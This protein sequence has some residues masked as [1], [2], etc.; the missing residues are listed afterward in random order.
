MRLLEL[1]SRDELSLI[2]DLVEDIPPYA[3]LSHTWGADDDEVTFNDLQSGSGKSKA[4]YTK[5]QFCGEQARKDGLQYFWVDTCCIDKSSSAELQEAINSMFSWYRDAAK[6]YVYLSDVSACECDNH[7]QTRQTWESAFRNSKWFTRGWTLQELIAPKSVE[8]FS[9]ERVCLGNK[10]GLKQQIHEITGIPVKALRGAPLPDFSVDERMRWAEKRKTKKKEDKA[11][12]L[13]GIF[14]IFMPLIYGE[15]ENAFIRL[16]EEI[17][18]RKLVLDKLPYAKGAM[19]NSYDQDHTTCH[20]ATRVDL[21]RQIKG[22]ARQPHSKSIFW[23]NGMAGTGKSTI[24]WTIAEWL[25]GQGCDGDIDLGASFFFKRGEGDRGSAT[26]FFSTIARDL[27][28]KVPGLY[29]LIAEVIASDPSIFD[30][31]LGEQFDKLI[32][33]PLQKV[34]ITAGGCSTFILVVDALDECETKSK[35]KNEIEVILSLWPQISQIKTIRLKLFL[36]SRPDL[37]IRLGFKNMSVDAHQDM[38]LHEVPRTTIE[39][40]ISAFLRDEF[41]KI[42][43]R[44]N[45]RLPSGILDDNWPGDKV[46]EA[47]VN[48]A[49]PLFIVAATICRYVGDSKLIPSKP[50]DKIL[51][52]QRKGLLGQLGQM[53]QTYLPVLTQEFNERDEEEEEFYQEFQKIVGSIVTLAEP[54]SITSLATLLAVDRDII[55]HHVSALHS[56]LRFPADH[57]PVR[58]FHLSFGEFL[59]SDKIRHKPFGVDGRAT[60][61]MLLKKCLELLSGSDGLRENLCD[62]SYPGQPRQELDSTI[63][64][65]RLSPALQ[66]TCRYWVHHTQHSTVQIHDNDEVH[67][68]L[69]KH[70]LH[71]LEALSLM[72]RIAEVIGHVGVLQS[73]VSVSNL[74]EQVLGRGLAL[75]YKGTGQQFNP[76]V[77]LS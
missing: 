14:N 46:L 17:N 64:N 71:W 44:Y 26:R 66:Y 41:S 55:V 51:E 8:F 4:G 21:L 10:N 48:M 29:S 12:C 45:D 33:Q 61:Q 30:K 15:G 50:L 54:L 7:N 6:C 35:T 60:H 34:N 69:K 59:L 31:A 36:T 16:K 70:F 57:E 56:V 38:I 52:F 62:L 37:P 40:D 72:N 75:I 25:T 3:I 58:T 47:L 68:F 5:I 23:L 13:L 20:P 28:L 77:I 74:P 32:C 65:E 19:F 76:F 39:H 43:Q 63:I 42:R 9:P 67:V 11:Y 53:E 2:T 22:W 24:S 27:V 18:K 73:L 49:V 1:D